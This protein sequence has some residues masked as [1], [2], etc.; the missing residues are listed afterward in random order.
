MIGENYRIIKEIGSGTFGKVY[1]AEHVPS[2]Q[3][4]AIKVL[5]KEKIQDESDVERVTR[6]LRISQSIFHPHLVQLYNLLETSEYIFLIMEYL[7]GGE[8]YDYIV[9][10]KKLTEVEAYLFFIQIKSA[11]EYLH[12]INIVHRDLKPEN[13]LL[14]D[15]K[16]TLKLVDF[17]LGRFFDKGARIETACGSPCYAPPEMLSQKKYDPIKADIWS[18]GIV[19]FAMVA[20]YLPFDDEN[21]EVLYQ[22]IVNGKFKLP[23]GLSKELVDLLSRIININPE[24]RSSL[25]G[26]TNHPWCVKM[27]TSLAGKSS[28]CCLNKKHENDEELDDSIIK[29]LSKSGYE[30]MKLIQSIKTRV[31][32]ES[33]CHYHMLRLAKLNTPSIDLALTPKAPL[34]KKPI[35]LKPKSA[36]FFPPYRGFINL[37]FLSCKSPKEALSVL[38]KGFP[39]NEVSMTERSLSELVF[40][41]NKETLFV[42]QIMTPLSYADAS[43]LVIVDINKKLSASQQSVCQKS[44]KYIIQLIN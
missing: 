40:V 28:N 26:I 30:E 33:Y 41:S 24:K 34:L 32:C 12:S 18:L 2:K 4:V 19:L 36:S 14:S 21:T 31:F 9:A 6:E 8:L 11:I 15:S 25:I 23:H 27:K 38:K 35:P 29:M 13:L 44:I 22:K 39:V 3:L 7:S 37:D 1:S 16:K 43:Y 17:G 20:G 5:E 10:K 42:C